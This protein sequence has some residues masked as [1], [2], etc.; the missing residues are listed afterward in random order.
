[1]YALRFKK[2]LTDR[3]A[4]RFRA[5]GGGGPSRLRLIKGSVAIFAWSDARANA[6]D[7]GCFDVVRQ[8]LEKVVLKQLGPVRIPSDDTP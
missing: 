8:H 3:E 2:P 7:L 1:V 5:S 4:Q 6:P